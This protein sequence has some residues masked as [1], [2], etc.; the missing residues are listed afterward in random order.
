MSY[1]NLTLLV[2]YHPYSS[3]TMADHAGVTH[4]LFLDVLDGK[5]E[6]L[7]AELFGLSRLL[8]IPMS[9]LSFEKPIMLNPAR[10][11]HREMVRTVLEAA[12]EYS[13]Y[14]DDW[15]RRYFGEFENA[16]SKGKSSYM[17]YLAL[18]ERIDAAKLHREVAQT[19]QRRRGRAQGRKVDA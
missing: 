1:P 4:E 7:P 3:C 19:K 13:E 18:L 9:V 8:N 16:F 10:R 15:D 6:L 5:E 12:D 2:R 17:Q 11:K 14:L